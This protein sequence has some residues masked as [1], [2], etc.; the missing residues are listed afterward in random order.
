M[1]YMTAKRWVC[2]ECS[3]PCWL[4]T[5]A[6]PERCIVC[7]DSAEWQEEERPP[8]P[9]PEPELMTA[10]EAVQA[11]KGVGGSIWHGGERT[12][13]VTLDADGKVIEGSIC[14]MS[15]TRPIY[16]VRPLP[17]P[18]PLDFAEAWESLGRGETIEYEENGN[19][20]KIEPWARIYSPYSSPCVKTTDLHGKKFRIADPD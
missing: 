7:N 8:Q 5:D 13:R 16:S 2:K 15:G 17:D 19:T 9:E 3:P 12:H 10:V 4:Q 1:R 14:S 11:C 18:Y 20:F 6:E